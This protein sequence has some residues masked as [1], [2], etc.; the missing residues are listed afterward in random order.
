MNKGDVGNGTGIQEKAW[1]KE[2][3]GIKENVREGILP[4]AWDSRVEVS[5]SHLVWLGTRYRA[6]VTHQ[7]WGIQAA[8][9]RLEVLSP[10]AV[11]P[12]A[13]S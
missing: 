11:S 13:A 8:V 3:M 2:R 6:L 9:Y 4:S 10:N 5:V 12:P 7:G 1:M